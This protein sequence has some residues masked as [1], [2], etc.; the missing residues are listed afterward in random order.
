MH[1]ERPART[2]YTPVVSGVSLE[3]ESVGA[4]G[5]D[6]HRLRRWADPV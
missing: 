4:A 6:Q 5:R 3:G 1:Q 2:P